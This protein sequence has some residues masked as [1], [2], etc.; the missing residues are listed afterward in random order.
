MFDVEVFTK[1]T[2]FKSED[3]LWVKSSEGSR[4]L[5]QILTPIERRIRRTFL[6]ENFKNWLARTFYSPFDDREAHSFGQCEKWSSDGNLRWFTR[7]LAEIGDHIRSASPIW[8]HWIDNNFWFSVSLNQREK[9]PLSALYHRDCLE[10]TG[11]ITSMYRLILNRA[12]SP[13][14]SI[15]DGPQTKWI[16]SVCHH[17]TKHKPGD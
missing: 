13:S 4:R 16:D 2:I 12:Q 10:E 6:I 8:Y 5:L 9:Q 11:M 17:D 1:K 14:V 15:I 3:E 7:K